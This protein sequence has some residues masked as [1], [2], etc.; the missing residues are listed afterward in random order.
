[1]TLPSTTRTAR[2][3]RALED[4]LLAAR[5]DRDAAIRDRRNEGVGVQQIADEVGL[6]RQAV[7]DVLA[8][9]NRLDNETT[10]A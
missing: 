10:V 3:V 4:R 7:Y 8:S 2:R 9:D 1:M 6:T 5:A